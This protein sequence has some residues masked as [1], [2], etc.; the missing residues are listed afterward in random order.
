MLS[1]PQEAIDMVVDPHL[2]VFNLDIAIR[3]QLILKLEA[4]P[5][6]ALE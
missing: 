1:S 2:F 6:L 3:E 4:S 5:L